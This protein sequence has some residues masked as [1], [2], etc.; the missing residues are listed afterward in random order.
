MC[1]SVDQPMFTIKYYLKFLDQTFSR[2]LV[3]NENLNGA[4]QPT[5]ES[6]F[7]CH[8]HFT[9]AREK[10]H[11]DTLMLKFTTSLYPLISS[12]AVLS[13]SLCQYTS[14]TL[15]APFLF[16]DRHRYLFHKLV[17]NHYFILCFITPILI[18]QLIIVDFCFPGPHSG[19]QHSPEAPDG[20]V[21]RGE[22]HCQTERDQGARDETEGNSGERQI[23]TPTLDLDPVRVH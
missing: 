18:S 8:T 16:F 14:G 3:G 23:L 19:L 2:T 15:C 20:L 1:V 4:K 5:Y 6:Y 22:S 17:I 21:H 9:F 7:Q 11:F 13:S 10:F 12:L